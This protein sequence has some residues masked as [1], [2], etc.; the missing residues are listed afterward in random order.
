MPGSTTSPSSPETMA[1]SNSPMTNLLIDLDDMPTLP[2]SPESAVKSNGMVS[3]TLPVSSSRVSSSHY[4][5]RAEKVVG[6]QS[7]PIT[8]SALEI[9]HAIESVAQAPRCTEVALEGKPLA[10]AAPQVGLRSSRYAAEDN[11]NQDHIDTKTPK[12]KRDV[13]QKKRYVQRKA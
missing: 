10:S 9:S 12:P 7:Q 5:R 1:P 11:V 3:A 8:L 6:R 2:S 13:Q 4:M